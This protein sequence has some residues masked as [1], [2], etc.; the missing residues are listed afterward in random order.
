MTI[1][2]KKPFYQGS[3]INKPRYTFIIIILILILI[4]FFLLGDARISVHAES[5]R[6][7]YFPQTGYSIVGEFLDFFDTANDPLWIFGYPITDEYVDSSTGL[8]TQF[9]QR[10][11]FELIL[12]TD[13]WEVQLTPLGYLLHVQ[14]SGRTVPFSTNSSACRKFKSMKHVCYAFLNFYDTHNGEKYFGDPISEAEVR[15]GRY[16]QYFEKARMEW[17]PEM[18]QGKRISLSDLGQIFFDTN[19]IIVP[20]QNLEDPN[21]NKKSIKLKINAFVSDAFLQSN[22][23]QHVNVVVQDQDYFPLQG[24]IVGIVVHPPSGKDDV[25]RAVETNKD[26]I[27]SI[28]FVQQNLNVQDIVQI[29]VIVNYQGLEEHTSTWYRVW[30]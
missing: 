9:F 26:G 10:A 19:N 21:I 5:T 8:R 25:Y 28:S 20:S 30:W 6:D 17:R 1:D 12:G 22:G 13:G 2:Q 24:V 27:T 23:M 15:D 16:V 11:R 29:E 3:L 18:P 14:E 7:R 4:I